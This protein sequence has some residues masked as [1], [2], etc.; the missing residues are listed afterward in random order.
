[1]CNYRNTYHYHAYPFKNVIYFREHKKR[2]EE[3]QQKHPRL[4][5]GVFIIIPTWQIPPFVMELAVIP[6]MKGG[7]KMLIRN[8]KYWL[9][10]NCEQLAYIL[11]T[12]IDRI[13]HHTFICLI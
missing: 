6:Q 13:W 3:E 12:I 4:I 1:M 9:Y 5:G 7:D 8:L 11:Y 2:I 10:H